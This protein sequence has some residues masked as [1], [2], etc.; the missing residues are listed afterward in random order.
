MPSLSA[1]DLVQPLAIGIWRKYVICSPS[2]TNHSLF[3]ES[4]CSQLLRTFPLQFSPNPPWT[5]QVTPLGL[6]L[7]P[8]NQRLPMACIIL[9]PLISF[10]SSQ[11]TSQE[12]EIEMHCCLDSCDVTLVWS[13]IYLTDWSFFFDETSCCSQPRTLTVTITSSQL[14]DDL[15]YSHD[16]K[17]HRCFNAP[18][19]LHNYRFFK[20]NLAPRD[21]LLLIFFLSLPFTHTHAHTLTPSSSLCSTSPYLSQWQNHSHNCW[22]QWP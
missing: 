15:K 19:A 6:P 10:L 4:I 2:T 13:S 1:D 21:L 18:K 5:F 17:Q 16:L 14:L 9:E 20:S 12:Q 8:P 7:P 11:W 3:S 22:D